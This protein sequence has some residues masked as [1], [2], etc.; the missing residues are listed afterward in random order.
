MR[1]LLVFILIGHTAAF[2]QTQIIQ[3]ANG[4]NI[5]QTA[6]SVSASA[7]SSASSF[8][9]TS[10]SSASASTTILAPLF[11]AHSFQPN[12]QSA[13]EIYAAPIIQ[14]HGSINTTQ[15][16]YVPKLTSTLA[17][18]E[19]VAKPLYKETEKTKEPRKQFAGRVTIT[20]EG[21]FLTD[22]ETQEVIELSPS[23]SMQAATLGH[24]NGKNV[25][26]DGHLVPQI[27]LA[28]EKK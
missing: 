5:S 28:D 11:E 8:G 9:S 6:I 16:E 20:K 27:N 14:H 23:N 12:K 25:I 10:A 15:T 22:A 1:A 7:S 19:T 2:S 13:P 3:V 18:G 4:Q 24:L 26:I 17:G 21:V